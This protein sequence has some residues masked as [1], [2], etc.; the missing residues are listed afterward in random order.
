MARFSERIGAL[1]APKAL[2]VDTMSDQLRNSLWNLVLELYDDGQQRRYWRRVATHIAR[3]FHNV[4]V[5]GL[6]FHDRELRRWVKD[7]FFS[8]PWYAAY[9]ITEFIVHNYREMTTISYG[10]GDHVSH[11]QIDTERFIRAVNHIL[12][13]ELSGFRFVQGT[14]APITTKEEI[15]EI[16]AA[17]AAKFGLPG[18][19]ER[20]CTALE[21]LGKKP[22]PDYRNT[23][24]EAISAV[25]SVVKQITK[26][27]SATLDGALKELCSKSE[28]HGAL[29]AGFSKLYG[30]T[31]DE[32][33]IRHALLDQPNIGFSEAK[34][35]IVSCSAF[36]HYLIQNADQADLLSGK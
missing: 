32:S 26:S 18:A 22:N 29:Q 7:L 3:Y 4:P 13:R 2:Q 20:I 5:D 25:E 11:H 27:E 28:I 19:R 1:E 24:K 31:S 12:E 10:Y 33:G 15:D 9:D 16:D 23:A 34:Y 14:L 21:L 6:P 35:M 17:A 8:L 36:V 30:Y